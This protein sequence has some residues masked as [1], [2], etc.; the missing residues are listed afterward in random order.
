MKLKSYFFGM[1]ILCL[2]ASCTKE[3]SLELAQPLPTKEEQFKKLATSAS[4]QL[5][6]VY[7]DIPVD[8]IENDTE[9][10]QETDLWAYVSP[11]LKDDVNTFKL[12][13]TNVTIEQR[14]LKIPGNNNA[15]IEREYH[16]GTDSA[17]VY[18]DFLDNEYK[19]LQYRLHELG[20]DYFVLSTPW[21][22][23]ATLYSRFELLKEN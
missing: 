18:M 23:G 8:F 15:I 11:Y 10:R 16:I 22:D 3:L 17:G 13:Y 21:Q 14:E 5:R 6:G 2:F 4:F 20:S 7:S 1:S 19:P 9:V 12:D